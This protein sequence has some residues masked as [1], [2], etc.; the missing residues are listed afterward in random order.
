MGTAVARSFGWR[1][2]WC[3]GRVD[4]QG[5]A[6][7]ALH[8]G[9]RLGARDRKL[10]QIE[11]QLLEEPENAVHRVQDT[12]FAILHKRAFRGSA[13]SW[14]MARGSRGRTKAHR[15]RATRHRGKGSKVG[16]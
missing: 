8:A 2:R 5:L 7:S 11:L 13:H 12:G 14:A 4:R 16:L 15:V 10:G 1:T 6:R 9:P 3:A